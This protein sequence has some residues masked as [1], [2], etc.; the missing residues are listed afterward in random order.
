MN[1]A[2][3]VK[4]TKLIMNV[5]LIAGIVLLATGILFTQMDIHLISNNK[6]LIALSLLPLSMALVYFLKLS[7]IK[8][9][10]HKMRSILI[11]ENDERLV[12]IKNEAD[13]KT[14][15][16]IQGALFL[17]Y[18]GY[19]FIVPE[20]IFKGAG[21]W[22]LIILLLASLFLPGMFRSAIGKADFNGDSEH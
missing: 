4:E 22:I 7:S 6:A 2:K 10:P 3:I 18:F 21:W 9:S 20:D 11:K 5:T 8:K 17:T 1:N 16:V 13:A 12:A 14:F 19:T 15:K